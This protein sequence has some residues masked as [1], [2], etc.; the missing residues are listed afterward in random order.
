MWARGEVHRTARAT[1]FTGRAR[2]ST[3]RISSRNDAGPKD[4][5][6]RLPT[7]NVSPAFSITEPPNPAWKLGQGLAGGGVAAQQWG[8]EEA[9]G[10]KTWE[11]V[12]TSSKDTYRLL[13]SAIVPRPI[14]LV[15]SLSADGIS[16][17][18]PF[19]YFSMVSHNPPLLSVCFSLSP[20]KPKDTRENILATKEFTVNII[21]EPFVEAANST[22]VDAPAE[23]DEWLVSGLTKEPSIT[24]KPPRVKE[25]AI[26]LECELYQSHDIRPPGSSDPTNTLVLGLI[27]T[28][29]V[30]GAVMNM[31]DG[32][33]DPQ[34]LRAVSRL[35]G[36]TYARIGEGFDLPRAS[37]KNMKDA[38]RS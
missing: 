13:T 33:V 15:S 9:S 30:R 2:F 23:V 3:S 8:H 25:S 19:S 35:G 27:K 31:D 14:A 37:W 12:E 21:S 4:N 7:F 11:L 6:S 18:A 24:V 1:T 26:H 38:F 22:S 16:N 32:T 36:M 10:W 34:K 5:S 28:V 20:K 29:H 17:L